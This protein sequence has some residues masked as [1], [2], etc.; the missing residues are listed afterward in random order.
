[1]TIIY[2][3]EDTCRKLK[4]DPKKVESL[5]RRLTRAAKDADKLGLFIFGGSGSGTLRSRENIDGHE[6][7]VAHL[8]SVSS[9]DGGDGATFEREGFLC[10]E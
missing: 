6:I 8:G 5:A 2:A 4:L 3:D 9:W 1:M 7:V 10:G